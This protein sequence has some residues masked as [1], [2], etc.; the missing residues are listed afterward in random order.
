M[1][2]N[3]IALLENIKS[4]KKILF[5]NIS[6][7][8]KLKIIKY[9]KKLQKINEIN[10]KNYKFFRWRYIVYETKINGKEYDGFTEKL[11]YEGKYLNGKRNG[12][13]KE[14]N[15]Y[16][17]LEFEGYHLNGKRNIKTESLCEGTRL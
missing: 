6:E 14:Y 16:G 13:G 12:K 5:D 3:V 10:F 11:I 9:N 1:D 8:I 17:T 4:K 7:K 15:E 2:Q